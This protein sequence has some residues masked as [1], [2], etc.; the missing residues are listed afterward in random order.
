[1]TAL[2][3]LVVDDNHDAALTLAELLEGDD[4]VTAEV[5]FDG[6]QALA[7]ATARPPDLVLIDIEMPG[8]NGTDAAAAIR[9]ALREA[10]PRICAMS[11]SPDHRSAAQASGTFDDVLAKPLAFSDLERLVA[12]AYAGRSVRDDSSDASRR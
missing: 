3:I 9:L 7:L 2:H 6:I 4:A 10:P 12:A 11:G 8:M 5:G 1:M